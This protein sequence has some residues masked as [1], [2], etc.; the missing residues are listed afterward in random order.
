MGKT[1]NRHDTSPSSNLPIPFEILKSCR[2]G[3]RQI[4]AHSMSYISTSIESIFTTDGLLIAAFAAIIQTSLMDCSPA[5]IVNYRDQFADDHLFAIHYFPWLVQL[6]L[7]P[8]RKINGKWIIIA[9]QWSIMGFRASFA[10]V[11][12]NHNQKQQNLQLDMNL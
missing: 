11:V 10:I 1:T 9:R 7:K 4:Q 3:R 12:F 2:K 6:V 8:V 5:S